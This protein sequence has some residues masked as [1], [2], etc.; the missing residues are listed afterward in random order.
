MNM[1]NVDF[2]NLTP[3]TVEVLDESDDVIS[4]VQPSG[5]VGLVAGNEAADLVNVPDPKSGVVYIVLPAVTDA[6][7]RDDLVSV[8]P[9]EADRSKR[10]N[11]RTHICHW[12]ENGTA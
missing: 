5:T 10:G 4:T 6:S 8:E 11:V 1:P 3:H 9:E 12:S 2:V 7:E